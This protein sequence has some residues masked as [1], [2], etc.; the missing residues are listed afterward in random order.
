MTLMEIYNRINVI[1]ATMH[2]DS[3][4]WFKDWI[5]RY[6]EDADKEH[7]AMVM[8]FGS[9]CTLVHLLAMDIGSDIA[10]ALAKEKEEGYG[11]QAEDLRQAVGDVEAD[12]DRN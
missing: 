4:D 12:E 5:K 9:A 2:M 6:P 7:Y 1:D 11:K 10:R 3:E 8:Q